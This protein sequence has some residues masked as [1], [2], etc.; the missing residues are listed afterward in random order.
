MADETE[1]CSRVRAIQRRRACT[2]DRVVNQMADD[3]ELILS[4]LS[5]EFTRDGITVLVEIFRLSDGGGWALEVLFR[6]EAASSWEQQ[7]PTDQA[8]FGYFMRLV[9]AG[10]MSPFTRGE[11][12]IL[13]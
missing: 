6:K 3:L 11:P 1:I 4:P 12:F 7:F 8:A 13:H 9:E 10:G 5:G 2:D